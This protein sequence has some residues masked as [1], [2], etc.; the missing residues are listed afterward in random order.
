MPEI[1]LISSW[2]VLLSAYTGLWGI[3]LLI[4]RIS[5]SLTPPFSA[6]SD[7]YL[8]EPTYSNIIGD[9]LGWKFGADKTHRL[10]RPHIRHQTEDRDEIN[11]P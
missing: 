11:L 7:V 2:P 5:S 9:R 3:C 1:D 8:L 10:K 6:P 4:T